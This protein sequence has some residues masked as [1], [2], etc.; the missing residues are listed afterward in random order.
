MSDAQHS[1]LMV[2]G[3]TPDGEHH[4]LGALSLQMQP[5]PYCEGTGDEDLPYTADVQIAASEAKQPIPEGKCRACAGDGK[6]PT[7]TS[8]KTTLRRVDELVAQDRYQ[9]EA[10]VYVLNRCWIILAG[11]ED[12]FAEAVGRL[13]DKWKGMLRSFA[14]ARVK[15]PEQAKE[16]MLK[17][18]QDF[19]D[20]IEVVV[21]QLCEEEPETYMPEGVTEIPK[22]LDAVQ[23]LIDES[24]RRIEE[25]DKKLD[26]VEQIRGGLEYIADLV[27]KGNEARRLADEAKPKP[28]VEGI[29]PVVDKCD[30]GK[31][32]KLWDEQGKGFCKRHGRHLTETKEEDVDEKDP[33][34]E[35]IELAKRK[36]KFI[37]AAV[38]PICGGE[39]TSFRDELSVVEHAQSGLCQKCQDEVFS[40][41]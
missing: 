23:I 4:E 22:G 25:V 15:K 36:G 38:C 19:L 12:E 37:E 27:R 21:R 26:N 16:G 29:T 24:T 11:S 32:A 28:V 5:C 10:D 3:V 8:L 18:Q 41:G 40:K 7:L 30:C 13:G 33:L 14:K 20:G 34:I 9:R 1:K 39:A 6:V 35:A 2:A 31:A 17:V